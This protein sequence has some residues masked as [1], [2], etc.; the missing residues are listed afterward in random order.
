MGI[1]FNEIFSIKKYLYNKKGK[2]R[3]N[4]FKI[5]LDI[6]EPIEEILLI[7][8]KLNYERVWDFKIK[9]L[10]PFKELRFILLLM[11]KVYF[12]SIN[13]Q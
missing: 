8:Y 3:I 5:D 12:L 11:N 9:H 13:Y 2:R 10:K 1:N 7:N 6:I 4:F